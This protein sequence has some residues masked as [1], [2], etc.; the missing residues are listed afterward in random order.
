[1]EAWTAEARE[2][3]GRAG[4]ARAAAEERRRQAAAAASRIVVV[5][6]VVGG[7]GGGG[8]LTKGARAETLQPARQPAQVPVYPRAPSATR[9]PVIAMIRWPVIA[10]KPRQRVAPASVPRIHDARC[11][12]GARGGGGGSEPKLLGHGH[13]VQRQRDGSVTA[14]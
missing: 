2:V 14:A 9:T 3:E 12:G 7:G 1:M 10:V 4:V 11:G 8:L 6:V 13:L 5:V